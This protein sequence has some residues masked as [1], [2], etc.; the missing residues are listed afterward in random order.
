MIRK[1]FPDAL[2]AL[3]IT[4]VLNEE[5]DKF[6]RAIIDLSEDSDFYA[7][8]SIIAGYVHTG[9]LH[10]NFLKTSILF[11]YTIAGLDFDHKYQLKLIEPSQCILYDLG[12]Y[13]ESMDAPDRYSEKNLLKTEKLNLPMVYFVYGK[14]DIQLDILRSKVRVA[15]PEN[16]MIYDS[17][18]SDS[19]REIL[20][21][22][23]RVTT[24]QT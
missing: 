5:A 1:I 21:R 4:W 15:T 12:N 14:K 8:D 9:A 22:L 11:R 3:F 16:L 17:S 19:L 6:L 10:F 24:E 2:H 7:G 13:T 20:K 18:E 23:V